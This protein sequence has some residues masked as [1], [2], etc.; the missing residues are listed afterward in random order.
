MPKKSLRGKLGYEWMN[1]N[2]FEYLS[3]ASN[4]DVFPASE[5][6]KIAMVVLFNLTIARNVLKISFFVDSF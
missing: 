5:F 3:I 2:F 1:W 6:G 4:I